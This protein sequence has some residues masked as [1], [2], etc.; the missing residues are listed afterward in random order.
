V[1]QSATHVAW[2]AA[3]WAVFDLETTAADPETAR[4]VTATVG[5]VNGGQDTDVRQW[6]IDPGIEIPAEATNVYGITTEHAREH[7]ASPGVALPQ[8]AEALRWSWGQGMP[9]VAYNATYDFTV[10]D[11]EIRAQGI[12]PGG[13]PVA[14]AVLDPFVLDRELDTYRKGSRTLTSCC[15]HYGVRLDGARDAT[16]DA[17]AAARVLWALL[18][19]YPALG[20]RSLQDPQTDQARWHAARQE[21]FRAYL[22]R[23]WKPA[24]DVDGHWPQRP[25]SG[26]R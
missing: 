4:I 5:W 18:R 3:R 20:R 13:F 12:D 23:V 15:E 2:A 7:G 1:T 14:G 11:R 19:K 6:L 24:D 21:S 25:Y 16:A 17:V 8:I 10:T 9:V 22:R 26:P